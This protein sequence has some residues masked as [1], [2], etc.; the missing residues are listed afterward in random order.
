MDEIEAKVILG[1]ETQSKTK[2]VYSTLIDRL[3]KYFV[4]DKKETKLE[5]IIALLSMLGMFIKLD[6]TADLK[7]SKD[8][9]GD[10]L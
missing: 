6:S 4:I 1:E 2:E 7:N 9:E 8:L 3:H 5:S 10:V